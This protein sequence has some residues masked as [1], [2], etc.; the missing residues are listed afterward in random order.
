MRFLERLTSCFP[1][2]LSYRSQLNLMFFPYWGGLAALVFSPMLITLVLSFARYDIFTPPQWNG[3]ANYQ[4]FLVDGFFQRALFN[5][6]WFGL[7]AVPLR[8]TGALLLAVSLNRSGRAIELARAVVY[9]PTILPEV[10]YALVWV[11]ILNP[12][13]GPLNFILSAFGLPTHV[14]LEET[15]TA[16]ASI[17]VMWVF[18]LGE[19]FVLMLAALQTIAPDLF[20]AALLDG[21]NRWQVFRR[22]TLPLMAPALLL[23]SVR[24][25]VL[26]L[27]GSF[28]PALFATHTGPYYAT[29]FLPHYIFD[30]SFVLF[31]YGYGSAATVAL[32]AVTAAAILIQYRLFKTGSKAHEI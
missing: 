1:L 29:Y 7:I 32:C 20:E 18:Q 3:L 13:F 2:R 10:A 31:R 4:N 12:G 14:W 21:A 30:E 28:T 26:S 17:V 16:R 22:I 5:S 9:L 19:G 11:L 23:L 6:V 24:D 8:V 15:L 25:T 27:Q